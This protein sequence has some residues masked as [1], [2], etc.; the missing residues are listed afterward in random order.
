MIL[1]KMRYKDFQF[2]NN[3]ETTRCE[4]NRSLIRHKYP[5][6]AGNELEDFGPN[7][8]IIS[9]TGEFFGTNAYQQWQSL[10]NEFQKSGVGLVIHPIFNTITRGVMTSLSGELANRENYIRYTFEIV[11]DT[12]P[13]ISEVV[14]VLSATISPQQASSPTISNSAVYTVVKGD[15]L[16]RICATFSNRYGKP[17]NWKTIAQNNNIGNPNLIFPGQKITIT[18]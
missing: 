6:L 7:A 15:C 13:D 1:Q 3:P 10:Y 17:I 2:P 5:E 18:W 12:K 16:S 14:S 8:S 9:G 4:C 11:A